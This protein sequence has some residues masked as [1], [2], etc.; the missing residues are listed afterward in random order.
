VY[1]HQLRTRDFKFDATADGHGHNQILNVFE[2]ASRLCLAHRMCM[3]C[4]ANNVVA[5]QEE[6]TILYPVP[7]FILRDNGQQFIARA[8]RVWWQASSTIRSVY[9]E[10]GSRWKKGFAES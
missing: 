4:R 3:R 7:M 1:L 5:V 6:F 2:S 9:L 10:P 8:Q